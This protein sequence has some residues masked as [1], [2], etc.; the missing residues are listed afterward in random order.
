LTKES[1]P[2]KVLSKAN[3]KELE[4]RPQLVR[5]KRTLRKLL[6]FKSLIVRVVGAKTLDLLHPKIRDQEFSSWVPYASPT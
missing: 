4:D 2:R 1:S 6:L 3:Q 5:V